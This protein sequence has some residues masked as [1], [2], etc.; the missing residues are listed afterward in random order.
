MYLHFGMLN[1]ILPGLGSIME[2]VY[3]AICLRSSN[4]QGGACIV[5][6]HSEVGSEAIVDISTPVVYVT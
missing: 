1:R 3:D 6:L 4:N 5:L 2:V